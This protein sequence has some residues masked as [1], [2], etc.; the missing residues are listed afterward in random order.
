MGNSL[1]YKIIFKK[2]STNHLTEILGLF[3]GLERKEKL[4]V[5]DP[6]SSRSLDP[7][8]GS[9]SS[10]MK[11]PRYLAC[12]LEEVMWSPLMLWSPMVGLGYMLHHKMSES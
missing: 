5:I 1:L 3:I 7:K 12:T 8:L 10:N 6:N 11:W 4:N 2:R 9:A